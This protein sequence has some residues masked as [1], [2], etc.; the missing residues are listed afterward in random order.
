[1]TAV[2][3]DVI[4]AGILIT[5][6][7]GIIAC[8]EILIRRRRIA[9]EIA[10]KTIH[11]MGGFGCCLFPFMVSSW[12]TVLVLSTGFSLVFYLGETRGLLQS[13]GSV[14]RKSLGSLLF[15]LAILLLFIVAKDRLWLY[16]SSLFV[17]VLADTAA[18]LAGT[19]YGSV[20]FQTAPNERKSL[21]GTIAFFLA[22]FVAVFTPLWTLSDIPM[23][24]CVLTALLMA[25]LLAGLE[26]ISVGGTDNLFVPLAALF[27][28]WKIPDKPTIEILF[29]IASL[30]LFTLLIFFLNHRYKSLQ[31]RPLIA[32]SLV[33]YSAWSLGSADWMSPL[34]VGF[35]LYNW[36]CL[37]CVPR[38]PDTTALRILRPFYP[39][40][41]ILFYANAKM[42]LAFWFGPFL[43]SITMVTS[44]CV[45]ERFRHEPNGRTLHGVRLALAILLP[46]TLSCLF[47]LPTQGLLVFSALPALIP[48]CASATLGYCM[49]Y[50]R[51]PDT[52]PNKYALCICASLAALLYVGLQNMGA[53]PLLDPSTWQE[54]FR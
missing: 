3:H 54:V 28:L 40:L 25:L 10:R 2:W 49:F 23:V 53:L 34:L 13:L 46:C 47:C 44:L 9:P 37:G 17:L 24:T 6:F 7:L 42:E 5:F 20:F 12:I 18:A 32:F 41:I 8:S 38:P 16:L 50:R 36:I 45:A 27:L 39:A 22:G 1:M 30:V 43:A 15:P 48:M 11:L 51:Y 4:G 52:E 31:V 35:L 26:A 19:R 29:Q 33:T 14:K 21:E